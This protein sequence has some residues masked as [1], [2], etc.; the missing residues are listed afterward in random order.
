MILYKYYPLNSY[1]F[2]S[3]ARRGLY[4]HYPR[5]MNDPFECLAI[6]DRKY[7]KRDLK[8]IR[9]LSRNSRYSRV[10]QL[11]D[12]KDDRGLSIRLNN[13]RRQRIENFAFC[14]LSEKS[15]D[16]LMWSHYCNSHTGFVIGIEIEDSHLVKVQYKAKLPKLD[17]ASYINF[18][19]GD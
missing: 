7:S 12:I 10:R 6:L 17:A 18:L 13:A 5:K 19:D 11:A 1:T 2:R 16:V 14:A 15:D 9:D 4:C 3:L 8:T